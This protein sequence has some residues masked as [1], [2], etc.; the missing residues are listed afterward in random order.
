MRNGGRMRNI[1]SNKEKEKKGMKM[2]K[3]KYKNT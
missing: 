2:S 1:K 3:D